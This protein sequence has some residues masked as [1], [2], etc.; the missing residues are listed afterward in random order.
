MLRQSPTLA[1][2]RKDGHPTSNAG[3]GLSP[4]FDLAMGMLLE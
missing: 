4:G 3:N 2:N 1:K